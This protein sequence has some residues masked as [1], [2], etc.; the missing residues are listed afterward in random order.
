MRRGI[1]LDD[2]GGAALFALSDLGSGVTPET[3]FVDCGYSAVG[4]KAKDAPDITFVNL[5]CQRYLY[6]KFFIIL[7][8]YYLRAF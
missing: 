5:L 2:V 6:S 8:K 3:I 7:K 4:M 1:T